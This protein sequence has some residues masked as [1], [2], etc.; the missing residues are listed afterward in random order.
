VPR[1]RFG[2]AALHRRRG[3]QGRLQIQ[4]QAAAQKTS[5]AATVSFV[6]PELKIQTFS[7]LSAQG[8][9]AGRY[10]AGNGGPVGA[11]NLPDRFDIQAFN[12]VK[13]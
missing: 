13:P 4:L 2:A 9:V 1:P 11:V 8:F 5:Q 12:V 3:V 7:D 10:P 6:Q